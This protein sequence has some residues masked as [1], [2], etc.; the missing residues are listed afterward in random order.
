MVE[1]AITKVARI[2]AHAA[3]GLVYKDSAGKEQTILP[4]GDKNMI[5]ISGLSI[6]NGSGG[7][8]GGGDNPDHPSAGA[9]YYAGSLA[10]GEI[11]E[12]YLLYQESKKLKN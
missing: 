1:N 11:T 8:T 10:D 12:R 9:D 5:D 6:S 3:Q 2:A 4:T 7:D